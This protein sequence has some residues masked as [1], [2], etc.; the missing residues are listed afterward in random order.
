M[1]F[2][3]VKN[4]SSMFLNGEIYFNFFTYVI[5]C[6]IMLEIK[7]KYHDLPDFDFCAPKNLHLG[8][9]TKNFTC[10]PNFPKFSLQHY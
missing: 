6:P 2:L 1:E 8:G 4:I 7:I 5:R 10:L 9:V 3:G